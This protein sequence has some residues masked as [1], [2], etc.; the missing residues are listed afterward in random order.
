MNAHALHSLSEP[1]T[2]SRWVLSA[3]VIVTAHAGA[4]AAALAYYAQTPPPG[5]VM[6]AILV[7][8]APT[9]EAPQA[10]PLDLAPGPQMQQ[11]EPAPSPPD[12]AVPSA[13][14][15]I[16]PTP[17]Q[18][19]L[20]VALPL[21]V[22]PMPPVEARRSTPRAEQAKPAKHEPVRPKRVKPD[23]LAKLHP[24]E[25]PPAPRSTAAPNV[26]RSSTTSSAAA[27]G[28]RAAAMMP[29]YRQ[30]LAAH[31][32]RFK[33]YPSAARAAGE[34]G[35]AML[36]FSVSRSGQ[37]LGARLARSSGHADL[38]AETLA[39]IRRAQPLPPIPPEIPQATLSFSVPVNYAVR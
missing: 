28:A 17:L 9:S 18:P 22:R 10:S 7:D 19:A 2:A 3:A 39:M 4:V 34:Q 35:T 21:E 8:M 32:Q 26:E 31:L 14:S 13:M 27:A 33:Q 1:A 16:E 25:Q 24:S 6:P 29:S 11:A 36:S 20:E 23:R 30:L 5:D 15:A 12:A 37:L 38:D